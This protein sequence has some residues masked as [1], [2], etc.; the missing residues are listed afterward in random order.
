MLL[1]QLLRQL[2]LQIPLQFLPK[3][4]LVYHTLVCEQEA[5]D[6]LPGGFRAVLHELG[7]TQQ[8]S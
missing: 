7:C 3:R 4:E 5:G 6:L 8:A 2:R 1:L